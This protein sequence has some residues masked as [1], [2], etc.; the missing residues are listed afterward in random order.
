MP[1][2]WMK[3]LAGVAAALALLLGPSKSVHAAGACQAFYTP[4]V[5]V[6]GGW[7]AAYDLF[8]GAHTPLATIDCTIPA[9]PLSVGLPTDST[10]YVYQTAYLLT[11]PDSSVAVTNA[12]TAAGNAILHFISTPASVAPGQIIADT[13]TPAAIP[14]SAIIQGKTNPVTVI[15]D[16]STGTTVT[17]NFGA[18]GAG[19][20]NGD[21]ITF[22]QPWVPIALSA[23][24]P[25]VGGWLTV[26]ATAPLNLS[27]NQLNAGWNYI[28]FLTARW[29]GTKWLVGCA[30]AVCASSNW[31][32]Q[33]ITRQTTLTATITPVAPNIADDT[34]LGA[35]VAT[36]HCAWSDASPCTA[37]FS[38][39]DPSSIY[40]LSG[41]NIIVDPAGP[42]V[43]VGGSSDIISV[44]ATQ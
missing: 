25:S 26:P 40:K 15:V 23:A 9:I 2:S 34:A 28:A 41:S 38:I 5:P 33:A 17:M 35:T 31:S 8:H 3:F 18:V 10:V 4:A 21:T 36:V 22:T 12:P 42:G 11:P 19:V 39:T 20:G 37:T 24:G 16:S 1:I 27:S 7:A 43:G 44:T 29:N 14:H 30:D 32:L 6:P 13:T